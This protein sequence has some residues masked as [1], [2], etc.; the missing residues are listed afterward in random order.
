MHGFIFINKRL[1]I[2]CDT[3]IYAIIANNSYLHLPRF[4]RKSE[5]LLQISLCVRKPTIWVPSRSDTLNRPVQSQIEISD[6]RRRRIYYP[7]SENKGADQLC[8]YCTA[9]LRLCFRLCKL[10]VF[11]CGGSNSSMFQKTWFRKPRGF[12]LSL[13]CRN[14]GRGREHKELRHCM[15]ALGHNTTKYSLHTHSCNGFY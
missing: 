4:R 2:S 14:R 15:L 11:P 12:H 8:S 10:L 7:C 13:I 5:W 3:G 1:L 6:F 9:D